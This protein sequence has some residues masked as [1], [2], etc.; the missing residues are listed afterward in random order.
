VFARLGAT[1]AALVATWF[2]AG[3]RALVLD[4][5]GLTGAA[6]LLPALRELRAAG[7]RVALRATDADWWSSADATDLLAV[8]DGWVTDG[9]PLADQLAEIADEL[10]V[11]P[12]QLVLAGTG[13][14]QAPP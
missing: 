12:A 3:C 11:T 10:D 9:R 8:L 1:V 14:A 2:G 5:D 7:V 4:G 13:P 6:H